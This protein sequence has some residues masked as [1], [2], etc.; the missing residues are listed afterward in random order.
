MTNINR[1]SWNKK[2]EEIVKAC[3]SVAK[4]DK[5]GIEKAALMLHRT[6]GAVYQRL[7][8]MRKAQGEVKSRA[9][10]KISKA[11]I[12]NQVVTMNIKSIVIK[13]NKLIINV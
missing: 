6:K 9:I 8:S 4:T 11:T 13:D 12:K 7:Y 5:E 1:S 3:V 2:E 10:T